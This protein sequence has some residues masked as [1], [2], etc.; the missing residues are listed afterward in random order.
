M[1]M[2][3]QSEKELE[4][5][6]PQVLL[7]VANQSSERLAVQHTA[8][9]AACA[10]VLVIVFGTTDLDLLIGKGIKLPFVDVEMPIVGFFAFTPFILVLAHFN[11]LLQLQLLSR[12]LFVFDAAVQQD[13]VIGGL[14]DRLHIF[15]FT[16]Y[17]VGQ[18]SPLV[19][20]FLAVMT[21]ITLVL[22]PLFVLFALQLEFL[23]YQ[24]ESVTWLQRIAIWLDVVLITLF[25]PTILHPKDDWKSY[26][27]ALIAAHVPRR[28]VWVSFL[29]L[30]AGFTIILFAVDEKIAIAGMVVLLLSVLSFQFRDNKL[31]R[32]PRR[33]KVI[34][35]LVVALILALAVWV[36][37]GGVDVPWLP[38]EKSDIIFF[39]LSFLIP[40]VVSWHYQAPRG[41]FALLLT[42]LMGSLLP[43]ALM[44]DEEHFEQLVVGRQSFRTQH[45]LL[46]GLLM[47]K[48]RLDLDEQLLF[49]KPP[50]PETLA[51]IRSGKW[52]EG[53]RQVEPINL[54]GRNLRHAALYKA[55]LIGADLRMVQLQGADLFLAK[56][57]G[58]KLGGA[59]L[60]SANLVGAGLQGADLDGAKLQGADLVGARLQGADLGGAELQGAKLGG[61]ELQGANLGG[62]GLQGAN[63]GGAGLQGADL[64]GAKLQGANL[65]GARLQGADLG[66]AELQG[67]NLSRA[68]LQGANLREA[69]LYAADF[70]NA[71]TKIID[72]REVFWKALD[73]SD[74][75][76]LITI[77]QPFITD[78][79]Q[80]RQVT[81]RLK[82]ASQPDAPHPEMESILAQA[83][84]PIRFNKRYSPQKPKEVADFT[85]QLHVYLVAL[86]AESPEIA[87]GIILQIPSS[88]DKF[89][90][91]LS[92]YG[93]AAKLVKHLDDTQFKGLYG[94]TPGEKEKLRSLE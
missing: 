6:N 88:D 60:Q 89:T 14:R 80:R 29:L 34:F 94:L 64:G 16:Y 45:T 21:S 1:L 71:A 49:V 66:G 43:L 42:L 82:R 59:G 47:D 56:L 74:V 57:Q 12:K 30:F 36:L 2:F 75:D 40:I 31:K 52:E 61:A 39:C 24:E 50:K 54:K 58:A 90:Q 53:L 32:S 22:L 10:Y 25:W 83:E 41:S 5:K 23:A 17:L 18:P 67:A 28:W 4:E 86:A 33:Y 44:V 85:R 37:A 46:S 8:F 15:P 72:A 55:M 38:G 62:V 81:A 78:T 26:W 91:K 35:S 51:L 87:R 13:E 11:L 65:G 3:P 63:L 93:L 19:K 27:R 73:K 77:L 84:I 9:I 68:K 48:R 20:P 70:T 7:D 76:Q 79:D 92:R 69:N